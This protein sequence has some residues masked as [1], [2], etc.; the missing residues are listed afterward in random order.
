MCNNQA[1]CKSIIYA[2]QT[3]TPTVSTGEVI[4][5]GTTFRRTGCKVKQDGNAIAICGSGYFKVDVVATLSAP[6]T[7]ILGVKLQKNGVDVIGAKAEATPAGVGDLV[8]LPISVVVTNSCP[9]SN[10][11]LSVVLEGVEPTK[12]TNMTVVVEKI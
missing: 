1:G 10:S 11:I 5:L 9:E 2:A 6:A 8:T 12:V 4:P 3:T 7:N